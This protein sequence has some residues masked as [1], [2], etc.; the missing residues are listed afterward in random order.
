MIEQEYDTNWICKDIVEPSFT[1]LIKAK[2][3]GSGKSYICEYMQ[4]LG[5]NVIFVCP[6]N[7]LAEK[8]G[9]NGV[10]INTFF[11]SVSV[12]QLKILING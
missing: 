6:T 10:T 9:E 8:Y 2:Y 5:H 3:A 12:F 11:V 7:E 1:L 4:K